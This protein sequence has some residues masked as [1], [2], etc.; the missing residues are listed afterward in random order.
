MPRDDMTYAER[1]A[2]RNN[3]L[4]AEAQ[5]R[6]AQRDSASSSRDQE[7][8]VRFPRVYETNLRGAEAH[9]SINEDIDSNSGNDE[10]IKFGQDVSGTSSGGGVSGFEEETLDIVE[11]DNTA[12]Q[13]IFLTKPVP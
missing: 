11:D 9:G 10:P 13:R 8:A 5:Q 4:Q 3:R 6:Q 12:G 2:E 1:S 7:Q